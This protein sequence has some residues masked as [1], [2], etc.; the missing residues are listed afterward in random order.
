MTSAPVTDVKALFMNVT[1]T[2]TTSS[3]QKTSAEFVQVMSGT[4]EKSED[5]NNQGA[6]S[7]TQNTKQA[8][9]LAAENSSKKVLKEDSRVADKLKQAAE[10]EKPIKEIESAVDEAAVKIAAA[11]MDKLNISEEELLIAMETLG[12]QPTDLLEPNNVMNLMVELTGSEDA[13]TLLT[14][15]ELYTDVKQLMQMAEEL[16]ATIK[17]QFTITDEEFTELISRVSDENEVKTPELPELQEEKAIPLTAGEKVISVE[18]SKADDVT[19]SKSTESK[20]GGLLLPKTESTGNEQSEMMDNGEAEKQAL[21]GTTTQTTTNSVGDIVE[22]VKEFTR[23]DGQEIMRQVTDYIKVNVNAD[24]TSIELR[25]HPESMG[26]VSAHVTSQNGAITAQFIVQ[27]EAVKAALET[28]LVQLRDKL[29]DQGLKVESI[30]VTVEDHD[31]SKSFSNEFSEEESSKDNSKRGRRQIDLN[32]LE[33]L[34]E[35][36]TEEE[37]LAADIM[38]V[39]GNSVDYSA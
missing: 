2:R 25:L 38:T 11:V 4:A 24:T 27:N 9:K 33:E 3:A 30:E 10:T 18:V 15:E 37:K 19:M 14:N 34:S 36:L 1:N 16:T 39:N 5:T 32:S 23:V 7:K 28:Q 26:T 12:L 17:E 20:E 31:L 6:T 21:W 13:L 35:E 8:S 29:N 22:T